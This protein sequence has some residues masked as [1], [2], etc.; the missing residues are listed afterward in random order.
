MHDVYVAAMSEILP[1]S[2][3]QSGLK[4]V[5]KVIIGFCRSVLIPIPG[6]SAGP[7]LLSGQALGRRRRR[8]PVSARSVSFI[9][10]N[11]VPPKLGRISFRWV[12]ERGP[13]TPPPPNPG[14]PPPP[15]PQQP[16][17]SR[18]HLSPPGTKACPPIN[19]T[20]SRISSK[21]RTRTRCSA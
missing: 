6:M 18:T 7:L 9:P 11:S 21:A 4:L 5:D 3:G 19:A 14:P 13:P 17:P 16:P 1:R 10:K 15:P 12:Q 8:M 2:T 20:P